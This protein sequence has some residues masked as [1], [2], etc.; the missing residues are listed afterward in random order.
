MNETEFSLTINGTTYIATWFDKEDDRVAEWHIDA[1]GEHVGKF[2]GYPGNAKQV[3]NFI[4]YF[5]AK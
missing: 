3:E 1:N 5:L 2:R 4:R